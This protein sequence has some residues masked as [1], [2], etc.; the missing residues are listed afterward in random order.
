MENNISSEKKGNVGIITCDGQIDS[1]AH[2]L[3]GE[4][5]RLLKDGIYKIV[6]DFSGIT[7][8][9]STGW[10]TIIGNLRESRGGGGDIKIAAMSAEMKH[11]YERVGF[12]E[13]IKSCETVEKA[14][15]SFS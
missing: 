11:A 9:S 5:S 15:L 8:I 1:D 7:F 12:D 13:L 3:K 4:V 14:I 6:I 10:G 2:A